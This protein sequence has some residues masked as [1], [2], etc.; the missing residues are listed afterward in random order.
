MSRF[1]SA[2]VAAL[3]A[4]SLAACT[5][6]S[7][8]PGSEVAGPSISLDRIAS[9]ND[10]EQVVAGELLVKFKDGVNSE[11]KAKGHGLGVLRQGH[12][13]A[14][15]VLS[16]NKG[17]E[18]A[19]ANI[20]KN[21]PD[22]LWAEPNYLRQPDAIDPKLWAFRNPGGLNMVYTSGG[23]GPIPSSYASVVD[24]DEDNVENYAAGGGDVVID[25]RIDAADYDIRTTGGVTLDVVLISV[26]NRCVGRG[27]GPCSTTR[28]SHVEAARIEERPQLRIDRVRLAQVIRLGPLDV[29]IVLQEVRHGD[30][31]PLIER[32]NDECAAV[33]LAEHSESAPF[34]FRFGVY[35]VLELHEQLT[36]DDLFRVAGRRD[37]REGNRRTSEVFTRNEGCIGASCERSHGHSGDCR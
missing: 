28:V 17:Q 36:G 22:V 35:S 25:T 7:V 9:A 6:H 10:A 11:S 30:L 5:D 34:R 1:V 21:D 31:L 20:L 32:E 16:L 33:S 13:S 2:S 12:G 18:I 8:A 19:M 37:S 15:V 14:F 27:N 24:A 3:A 4:I 29:G 23:T 26:E